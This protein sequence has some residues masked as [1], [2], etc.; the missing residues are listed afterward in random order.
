MLIT[1]MH[2]LSVDVQLVHRK[3][4][5]KDRSIEESL[6]DLAH[7]QYLVI[8][9]EDLADGNSIHVDI[10]N[11]FVTL[12]DHHH[13]VWWMAMVWEHMTMTVTVMVRVRVRVRMEAVEEQVQVHEVLVQAPPPSP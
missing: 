13:H 10:A 8:L 7:I 3:E 11:K 2:S 9:L 5:T 12:V 1:L 6:G 4:E